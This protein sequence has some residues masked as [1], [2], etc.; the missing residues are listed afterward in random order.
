MKYYGTV[1][2]E[3]EVVSGVPY[4]PRAYS[5]V[6]SEGVLPPPETGPV[7][8]AAPFPWWLVLVLVLVIVLVS[9]SRRRH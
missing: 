9:A 4:L 6:A 5:T 8:G 1:C 3:G 2:V 7:T